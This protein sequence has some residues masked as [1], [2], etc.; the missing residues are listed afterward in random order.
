MSSPVRRRAQ[1][2]RLAGWAQRATSSLT[3]RVFLACTLL[4][5][6]S[7]G[8]AF[9]FVDARA[10]DQAESDLRQGLLEAG[11]LLD[12]YGATRTD[13]FVRLA[14]VVADL[15]KLKAAVETGDPPTVQPLAEEY[16]REVDADFL[17]LTGAQ[18]RVL[19]ADGGDVAALLPFARDPSEEEITGF[20]P[21]ERGV[22][23]LVSVPMVLDGDLPQILGRLTVGLLLDDTL[24]TEVRNL[25]GSEIAFAANGS[26]LASTLPSGARAALLPALSGA[27]IGTVFIDGEEF[28][29]LARPLQPID[30][31]T[32]SGIAL[33]L[34]SR[35]ARMQ[36]LRGIR[37]GL[38]GVMIGTLVLATILSYLVARTMT[39]PLAAVTTAMREVASTGDLTRKVLLES[40]AWDDE[41]ARI[42]AS[43]F[44]TLTESIAR[45]QR[46]AAQK[47]RLSSLGRLSTVIAH[48]IRN[49]LMIIRASL[50]TLRN[51][52]ITAAER[53]EAIA[54]IDDES[55]RLN[56]IVTEVLDFA[57]PIRFDLATA[58]LNQI[59]RA[60]AAAAWTGDDSAAVA[61]DLDPGVPPVV[62]DAER[63]RTALVNILTNARHAV[64]AAAPG[65]AEVPGHDDL[66]APDAPV[67]IETRAAADRVTIEIRDRGIGITEHDMAHIFDPYFTT[68]RAGT[69]LGLPIAKNIIEGLGGS[70]AVSSRR[71]EGT[72]VRIDLP[73][74]ARGAAA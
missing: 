33:V 65:D 44:N 18:G 6:L 39:S 14:R 38:A 27:G 42:L 61:L 50:S 23:Q 45:F 30:T 49:P 55:M 59:C 10:S 41:D 15:P 22:L 28:V 66:P 58:D 57:R 51:D 8:F 19:G 73:Y 16:R 4:A 46:E 20:A 12:E 64:Q 40:R 68:R 36:F 26:I 52:R 63:L 21:H 5:M 60:S 31:F 71:G 1:T 11:T 25:T 69:G 53:R 74:P 3:N 47:D 35:T 34:R 29:V 2:G 17:V 43:T 32:G 24:A 37:V 54:D 70:L 62:T 13:H 56:R 7:L 9:T 72:D 48:E 67:R